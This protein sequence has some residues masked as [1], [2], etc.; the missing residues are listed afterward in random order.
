MNAEYIIGAGAVLSEGPVWWQGTLLWVDIERRRI[1]RWSPASESHQH[2]EFT[3]RLGF[4]IPSTRGDAVVG[5]D[6]TLARVDLESGRLTPWTRPAGEPDDH[7]FNDA[8]CDP[9]GRLWAGTLALSEAPELGILY[10][11]GPDGVPMPRV[12]KVTISNGLAWSPEGDILY[13]IDSATRRVD[14]FDFNGASASISNRR[15]VIRL[16]D[17]LPDGMA[18]DH[19]GNLWVALWGG[20][21]VACHDPR[22]GRRLA[23]VT[24]PVEAVTSCC[25]GEG[26]ALWITTASRDLD[27]AGRAAQPL[28]GGVFRAHVGIGG[29]PVIPFAG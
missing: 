20:W 14:A 19:A 11:V 26:D 29:P 1:H 21:K 12:P 5:A 25:F 17:G 9:S 3:H 8:K 23:E 28:A 2:W 15:T 27:A 7:R 22:T 16:E 24:L 18:I 4:V 13:F 10:V 6:A